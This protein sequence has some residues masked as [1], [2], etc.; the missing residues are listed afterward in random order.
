MKPI[1]DPLPYL[2]ESPSRAEFRYRLS[3]AAPE[4]NLL[5]AQKLSQHLA[6]LADATTPLRLGVVHT[7]TSDLADPW[8]QFEARL[9]GLEPEIYHAPYGFTEQEAIPGS[10]LAQFAPDV[11]LLLLRWEDLHPDLARPLSGFDG[12][13]RD[14]LA[15]EATDRLAG[16]LSRFRAIV[17]GQI[18]VTLLPPFTNPGLG[19]Y[20]IHSDASEAAWRAGVKAALASRLRDELPSTT[21]LDLDESVLHLGRQ[22]FFDLRLW[23]SSRF[24]FTS[25]AARELAR[26]VMAVGAVIKLPKLKVIAL[27][28]DN[29]LWGGIIGEDGIN[30]IA[31]G[32]DYPGNAYVAFQ[33]RL[34]DFQ[35][36]GFILVLCSKNNPDDLMQVLRE[37]PHQIL[38]EEHF[39]ALRVNWEPKPQNLRSLA[40]ELNLGLDSFVFVDDSDHECLAVRS[41]LPQ[42]E[43]LKT[44]S[45]PLD[46]PYCLDRVGRLEVLSLTEEDRR[47]TRMYVEQRQRRELAAGS[48]DLEGYLA[49]LQMTMR[50]RLD[51]LS[52]LA[53][54][55][56]LTQKTNQF[57]LTTRRYSEAD[58]R[59]FIEAPD[60]LVAHFSLSDVFGD[61]GIV[62]LALIRLPGEGVAELDTFLMSCRVIG[63][64]AETAF[65]DALLR[66]LRDRG[67]ERMRAQ[68]LPTAKNKLVE[69]FLPEHGFV[70]AGDGTHV[71]DFSS[72]PPA[73]EGAYPIRIELA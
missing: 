27:D 16:L 14:R 70:P 22:R 73:D 11:T 39:A 3:V 42:V 53:R 28:A 59:G 61:N 8:F 44:P 26:R 4:L 5:Q 20:D 21:F 41:E 62:G 19:E 43:V 1:Q 34:L 33:R 64:K 12:A 30:G 23:Y 10:G 54:L 24:P 51:D 57:N 35:Q 15:T 68:Y 50:I 52:A 63:R 49:S 55:A 72:A 7:Y 46:V 58:M 25:L 38:R 2:L 6:T 45:R 65:L 32:P 66:T 13:G 69:N 47:K 40:E 67:I 9:Q 48:S 17:P 18:V 29:T 37:H 36:R 71:R 60:W 31:L 56:Q